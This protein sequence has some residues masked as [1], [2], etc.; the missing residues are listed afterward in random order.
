[1]A[2]IWIAYPDLVVEVH[3]GWELNLPPPQ[4]PCFAVTVDAYRAFIDETFE[5]SIGL[6]GW[7]TR[8]I[9]QFRN[10]VPLKCFP[11]IFLFRLRVLFGILYVLSGFRLSYGYSR[12][13]LGTG[14][15]L[16]AS[17]AG[18]PHYLTFEVET[19]CWR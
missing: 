12:A 4:V 17:F 10:G 3:L 11:G 15:V 6:D 16:R 8:V 9:I 1:M 18:R 14:G 13:F 5:G 2:P 7:F 19:C